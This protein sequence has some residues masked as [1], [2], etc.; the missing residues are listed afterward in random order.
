M[1]K[2]LLYVDS[3]I[4]HQIVELNMNILNLSSLAEFLKTTTPTAKVDLSTMQIMDDEVDLFGVCILG[5]LT[6]KHPQGGEVMS[7]FWVDLILDPL[8]IKEPY[9]T[10]SDTCVFSSNS[11]SIMNSNGS[12]I[13]SPIGEIHELIDIDGVWDK[14]VPNDNFKELESSFL[15]EIKLKFNS[16]LSIETLKSHIDKHISLK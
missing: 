12:M 7:S 8:K 2:S 10:L 1:S 6:A 4:F 13:D 9:I 11:L 15:N 5:T 16:N 3:P 14:F